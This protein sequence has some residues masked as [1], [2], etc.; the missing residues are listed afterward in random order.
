[1]SLST[2]DFA[3]RGVAIA[4][5]V[6][7]PHQLATAHLAF[8]QAV[9][10]ADGFAAAKPHFQLALET[11]EKVRGKEHQAHVRFENEYAAKLVSNGLCDEAA[12]MLAHSIAF[13]ESKRPELTAM[14]RYLRAECAM[15]AGKTDDAVADYQRALADCKKA[16]CEPAIVLSTAG[17]LGRVL[18]ETG[19][20]RARG[21]ELLNEA[22]AGFEAK[23]MASYLAE[24]DRVMKALGVKRR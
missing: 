6:D 19:R 15:K 24:T 1:M 11:M 4:D 22:R 12:P 20:D 13:F 17:T 18:V 8:A 23:G 10:M 16:T 9:T 5:S 21:A 3:K 2:R 7:D 14:P